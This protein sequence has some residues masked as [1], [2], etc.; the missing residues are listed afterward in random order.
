[1]SLDVPSPPMKYTTTIECPPGTVLKKTHNKVFC[2]KK[3]ER[4]YAQP[5]WLK[6]YAFTSTNQPPKNKQKAVD[7]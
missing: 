2:A 5:P 3:K 7:T 1:M 4:K 6:Q